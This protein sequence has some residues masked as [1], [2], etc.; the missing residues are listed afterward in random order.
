[1]ISPGSVLLNFSKFSQPGDFFPENEENTKKK[2]IIG[3][4]FAI[5]RNKNN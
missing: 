3:T 5:F 2:R 4:F 1:M